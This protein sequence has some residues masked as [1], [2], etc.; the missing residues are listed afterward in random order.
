MDIPDST[1]DPIPELSSFTAINNNISIT[2]TDLIPNTMY[3][4]YINSTNS[5][6]SNLSDVANFTTEIEGKSPYYKTDFCSNVT[7]NTA[8]ILILLLYKIQP[9]E[10][11]LLWLEEG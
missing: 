8:V 11:Q 2:L 9:V 6:G 4:Y 3:F 1:S 5:V 10:F 7:T